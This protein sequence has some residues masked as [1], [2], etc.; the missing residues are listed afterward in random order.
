MTIEKSWR[1]LRSYTMTLCICTTSLAMNVAYAGAKEVVDPIQV[2]DAEGDSLNVT[3]D[4]AGVTLSGDIEVKNDSGDP[5]PVSGN[6]I[7]TNNSPIDVAVR[8]GI[9]VPCRS[10][11]IW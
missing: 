5:L 4:N 7:V 11:R 2:I 1:K 3:I 8:P 6:V 9:K 10:L